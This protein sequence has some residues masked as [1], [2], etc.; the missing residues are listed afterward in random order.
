MLILYCLQHVVPSCLTSI[1][2]IVEP[3]DHCECLMPSR[4]TSIN[5]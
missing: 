3:S 5:N 1:T 2:V 4:L